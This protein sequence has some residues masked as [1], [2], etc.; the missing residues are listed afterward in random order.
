MTG[1][2]RMRRRGGRKGV[3]AWALASAVLY[4]GLTSCTNTTS[5][6]DPLSVDARD[7]AGK[8]SCRRL[9]VS[10]W[11]AKGGGDYAN[12][13]SMFRRAAVIAPSEAVPLVA[14]G[15]TLRT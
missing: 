9:C 6:V 12:A 7:N 3:G 8:I 10:A 5:Y 14:A 13:V 1:Q 11:A 4:V 15:D 2:T